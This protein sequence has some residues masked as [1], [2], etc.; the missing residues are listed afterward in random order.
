MIPYHIVEGAA[1]HGMTERCCQQNHSGSVRLHAHH[2]SH[3]TSFSAQGIVQVHQARV[4][5]GVERA[6]RHAKRYH[7]SDSPLTAISWWRLM[8]DEAQNVGDGFSQAHLAVPL[9]RM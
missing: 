1:H 2:D 9:T 4:A 6:L 8:L 5:H 7:V 3:E